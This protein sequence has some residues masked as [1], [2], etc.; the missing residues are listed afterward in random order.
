[1]RI[2][3]FGDHPVLKLTLDFWNVNILSWEASEEE[4]SNETRPRGRMSTGGVG[5]TLG[6]ATHTHWLLEPPLPSIFVSR[7]STWPK[8]CLYIYPL[9]NR[10][11]WRQRNMKHRNRGCYSEDWRG[12]R[13]RSCPRRFSTLS[14]VNTIITAMKRE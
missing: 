10:D 7:C 6:R 11:R 9:D 12:K 13:C 4:E 14:D 2:L 3:S 5:P 1:L 8:K